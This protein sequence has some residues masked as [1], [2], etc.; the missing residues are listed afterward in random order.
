MKKKLFLLV[1]LLQLVFAVSIRGASSLS[2]KNVCPSIANGTDIYQQQVTASS[3]LKDITYSIGVTVGGVKADI[4]KSTGALSNIQGNGAIQVIATCGKYQADYVLT[5][6]YAT[7]TWDFYSKRLTL[8]PNGRLGENPK[9]IGDARDSIARL[10]ADGTYWTSFQKSNTDTAPFVFAYKKTVNGDNALIV[11][12]TAGLQFICSAQRFGIQNHASNVHFRNVKFSNYST[13]IIPKLKQGQYVLIWWNPYAGKSSVGSGSG[14]TFSA[15]NLTD[16]DDNDIDTKFA[17]TGL[18]DNWGEG[19]GALYGATCMKVKADGDVVL[20][21]EDIGWNDIVKIVVSNQN[22]SGFRLSTK[23]WPDGKKVETGNN[24]VLVGNQFV[25]SGFPQETK[26][27]RALTPTYSILEGEGLVDATTKSDRQYLDYIIT[28]K[29]GKYGRVKVCQKIL[30]NGTDSKSYVFDKASAWIAVGDIDPQTYPYTWDFTSRNSNWEGRDGHEKGTVLTRSNEEA[31]EYGVW[32][33]EGI[34]IYAQDEALLDMPIF[35]NG[36]Q[37]TTGTSPIKEVQ[38]LGISLGKSSLTNN[39]TIDLGDSDGDSELSLQLSTTD[40]VVV[41]KVDAGMYIFVCADTQPTVTSSV[42]NGVAEVKDKNFRLNDSVYAYYV[43]ATGDVKVSGVNKIYRIGVTNQVKNMS[44]DGKTTDSRAVAID[45][46]ETQK[47]TKDKLTAYSVYEDAKDNYLTKSEDASLLTVSPVEV[48]GAQTG[49]VLWNNPDEKP[50]QNVDVPLF[51]PAINIEATSPWADSPLQPNVEAKQMAASDDHT[52]YY[53]YT[54]KYFTSSNPEY[55]TGEQYLFYQVNQA[56]TLVA[57]KAY[58]KLTN[59][60]VNSAKQHVLLRF[61]D[62]STTGIS[63]GMATGDDLPHSDAYN[64]SGMKVSG[65]PV[66]GQ[67]LI[68][69]G[70]KWIVK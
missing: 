14:A 64:L 59:T 32:G 2:F 16:L 50:T 13:L 63:L 52:K 54:N 51:V 41:P 23:N 61:P 26:S 29:D 30:C 20:K 36:A 6:A 15:K 25:L 42:T 19:K 33:Q 38:G 56:G 58:L 46:S 4:D 43:S 62:D 37:L 8:T 69:D 3:D 57:N 22:T 35:A 11:S 18:C 12:Q 53:V 66:K 1:F 7:H 31:N 70:K 68:R 48:A 44:P 55:Q 10:N 39:K 28:P 45:Y 5:V 34:G 40:S 27:M 24:T 47:Y 49:V 9:E 17:V 65:T 21:L 67:I 60:S